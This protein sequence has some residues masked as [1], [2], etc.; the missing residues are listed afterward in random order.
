LLLV[1]W[2]SFGSLR[3]S[4]GTTDALL[5]TDLTRLAVD[6]Q[7]ADQLAAV[8]DRQGWRLLTIEKLTIPARTEPLLPAGQEGSQ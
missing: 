7:V 5:A 6:A 1:Q 4:G 2:T 8:A 3:E